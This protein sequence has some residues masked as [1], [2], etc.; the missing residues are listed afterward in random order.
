MIFLAYILTI[1]LAYDFF[2]NKFGEKK[3][4][5]IQAKSFI[6]VVYFQLFLFYIIKF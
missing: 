1:L 5:K 6:A 3:G 2:T 4:L